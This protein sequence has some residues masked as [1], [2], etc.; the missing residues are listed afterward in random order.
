MLQVLLT[1]SSTLY[2]NTP[3]TCRRFDEPLRGLAADT[4]VVFTRE[5]FDY[6]R[7]AVL[8]VVRCLKV[9]LGFGCLATWHCR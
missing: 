2:N 4:M 9:R 5:D 1:P 3:C 7:A 6:Q 8:G